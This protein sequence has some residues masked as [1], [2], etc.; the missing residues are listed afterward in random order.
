M[1]FAT[2]GTER[3]RIDSD[4]IITAPAQ[5]AFMAQRNSD[6]SNATGDGTQVTLQFPDEEYDQNNDFDGTSTFTAPVAGK[7]AFNANVY[8]ED[9]TTSHTTGYIIATTTS[10]TITLEVNKPTN[11]EAANGAY[12]MSTSWQIDM[13]SGDTCVVKLTISNGTKVIDIKGSTNKLNRFSGHLI[14]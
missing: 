8:L 1:T 10:D 5:C 12:S 13:A 7:Y 2:G 3:L 4:G 14:C 6:A 9:I 11:W